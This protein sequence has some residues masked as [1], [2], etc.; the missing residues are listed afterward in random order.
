MASFQDHIHQ[1]KRNLQFLSEVTEQPKS[2]VFYDWQVTCCFY[3]A[4]HLVNAHLSVHG[5]QYRSH[6]DVSDALNPEKRLSVSRVPENVYLAYTKLRNL[7]RRSRY[8]YS[9]DN[10]DQVGH[11]FEKHVAKAIRHLDTILKF[12][13][14]THSATFDACFIKCDYIQTQEELAFFKK[15]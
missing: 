11:A 14:T 9:E 4:V 7:S 2:Q 3:V 5:I 12:V 13:R 1:A 10:P 15:L 6:V 8:L